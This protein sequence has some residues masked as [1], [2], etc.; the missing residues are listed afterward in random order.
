LTRAADLLIAC[1]AGDMVRIEQLGWRP[2]TDALRYFSKRLDGTEL[3]PYASLLGDED[4]DDVVQ[5][6]KALVPQSK[7]YRPGAAEIWIQIHP[8]QAPGQTPYLGRTA[9]DRPDQT[10]AAYAAVLAAVALGQDTCE[11]FPRPTT[12]NITAAGVLTCPECGGLEPGQVDQAI[13]NL[14][15]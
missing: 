10:P 12:V 2:V 5:A 9:A 6:I 11:C 1:D 7:G 13:D 8:E 3:A 15:L 4:P 14:R